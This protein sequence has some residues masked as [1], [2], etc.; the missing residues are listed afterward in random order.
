MDRWV[1]GWMNMDDGFLSE[2]LELE[3]KGC[4][5]ERMLW[6]IPGQWIWKPCSC[7]TLKN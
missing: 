3:M 7:K 1:D 6:L 2:E 4:H 5:R